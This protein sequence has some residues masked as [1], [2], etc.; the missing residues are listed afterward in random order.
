MHCL[1]WYFTI[2]HYSKNQVCCSDN[3]QSQLE[4]KLRLECIVCTGIS[5]SCTTQRIRYIALILY[6]KKNN[7]LI[8]KFKCS[9]SICMKMRKNSK[10]FFS[11]KYWSRMLR[12]YLALAVTLLS[13]L[14]HRYKEFL[15]L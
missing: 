5:I 14:H 9:E 15:F 11:E 7:F 4:N 3:R 8:I 12:K 2:V 1:Y 10:F 13:G 6:K